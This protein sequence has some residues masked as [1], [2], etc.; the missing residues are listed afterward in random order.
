MLKAR[1]LLVLLVLVLL[2]GA[3]FGQFG[4]R[5]GGRVSQNYDVPETEFI[6]ARWSYASGSGWTH[7]Y[8][9]AEEHL[10]QVMSEATKIDVEVMSYKIVPLESDEI[11]DYPF[12]YISEPGQMELNEQEVKNFREFVDRGGFVML[13]DFDGEYMFRV[14][15][16]NM[17]RVFPDREM[18]RMTDSHSILNTYYKI[19]SLYVESPYDVGGKAEFFGINNDFGQL[20]V[21]ICYNNDIGDYWEWIGNPRYALRPSAEALRMGV[22]FVLYAMTH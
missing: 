4:R 14:M 12:G 6:F 16:G 21:I 13:D 22:N 11:F 3:A 9:D 17:Q 18:F 20:A 7:D 1:P 5:G 2:S 15:A 10:N 19:E 8:P